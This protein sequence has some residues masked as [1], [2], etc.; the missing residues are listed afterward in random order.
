MPRNEQRPVEF[1]KHA[2][3]R[4]EQRGIPVADAEQLIRHGAIRADA[5]C[6]FLAY[7]RINGRSVEVAC[8][9]LGDRIRVKTAYIYG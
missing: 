7:G 2:V 8:L 4:L 5:D 1:S 6:D 9:D 3:Q